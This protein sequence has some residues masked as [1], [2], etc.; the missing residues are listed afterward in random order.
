MKISQITRE[1]ALILKTGKM[2]RYNQNMEKMKSILKNCTE[3][4]DYLIMQYFQCV[5]VTYHLQIAAA[6]DF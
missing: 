2:Y 3:I 4:D 5:M 6:G 1:N